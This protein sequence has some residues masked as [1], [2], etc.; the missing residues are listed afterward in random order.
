MLSSVPDKSFA[1]FLP[2]SECQNFLTVAL[3][4]SDF[5]CLD[6]TCGIGVNDLRIIHL[7]NA[8]SADTST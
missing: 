8:D 7:S 3:C 5:R 4:H 2:G 1:C 6:H